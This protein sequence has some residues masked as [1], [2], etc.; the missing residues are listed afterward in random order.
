MAS[1]K[2]RRAKLSPSE[3]KAVTTLPLRHGKSETVGRQVFTVLA[4]TKTETADLRKLVDSSHGS[5]AAGAMGLIRA[6][7]A[8]WH[9]ERQLSL[10]LHENET[11]AERL[12]HAWYESQRVFDAVFSARTRRTWEEADGI[13]RAEWVELA[14]Q[15]VRSGRTAVTLGFGNT[16][17]MRTTAPEEPV[18]VECEMAA[19]GVPAPRG[20]P[21]A[22]C[23]VPKTVDELTLSVFCTNDRCPGTTPQA[24]P[25]GV[26]ESQQDEEMA[27]GDRVATERGW[28]L[29]FFV[30][31]DPNITPPRYCTASGK[32]VCCGNCLHFAGDGTT[33]AA[34]AICT[35]V[36]SWKRDPMPQFIERGAADA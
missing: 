21:C 16:E 9:R 34:C 1:K 29:A 2:P 36:P 13:T 23:G 20:K 33:A 27:E 7:L 31:P 24:D 6:G 35:R 30:Q 4:F 15:V 3:A 11:R 32:A 18:P 10:P 22:H 25:D 19:D 28:K 14:V 17:E 12:A 8:R 26:S 5:A